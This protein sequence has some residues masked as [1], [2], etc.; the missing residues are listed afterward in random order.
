MGTTSS[1]LNFLSK[2][3]A[4]GV[5]ISR[6]D[7]SQHPLGAISGWPSSLRTALSTTLSAG[8]P[9]FVAWGADFHTFYNAA[10]K[11]IL[12]PK[13]A[14]GHGL[15]LAELWSEVADVVHAMAQDAF[16]G[17]TQYF[18]DRPFVLDRHGY[19]E[20]A[21]FTFCFS[22]IRDEH[23]TVGGILGTLIETTEKVAALAKFRD[24][25]ERYRL[26]LEASG[27]IGT[28][29][30]DPETNTAT[31]DAYF[32][33]L[34]DVDFEIAKNGAAVEVFTERIHPEDRGSVEAAIAE[35]I[36]TGERYDID[37]RIVQRSGKVVW[38]TAKGKL[39]TDVTT[40]KQ[41]FAG[42]SVEITE[43]KALEN[44]LHESN[45]RKDEFLAMLA[46][47][48]RNPL[49]PISAAAQ[50]LLTARLD[51]ERIRKT[52]QIIVRQ[53]DH[54]TGLVN[55]LLDVSRVTRGLATIEKAPVEIRTI[56]ADA[57]EQAA[58]LIHTRRH[59]LAMELAP[60]SAIVDV[61]RK[62]LV[63][64]VANVLNNAAKYT[65][66]DGR[67]CLRTEVQGTHVLI[68]VIDNGIGMTPDLTSQVFDLFTQAHATPD[69][70]SGGLGLGLALVKSLVELHGGSV[71]A[72]SNGLGHGSRFA[73][74]LP[75]AVESATS[76]IST[77]VTAPL[78]TAARAL[79]ILVVDDN[80]DAAETIALLLEAT[81]H[82][83]HIE[84]GAK[85]ALQRTI[86]EMPEVCLLDIGLPEMNGNELARQIRKIPGMDTAVLIA[87]TGYGQEDD[88]ATT[89]AAGFDYHFVKPV[90]TTELASLLARVA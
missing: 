1:D 81:G 43:R 17:A 47:E 72:I 84:Y 24:S 27:N 19:L 76:D 50:L 38:V 28:W 82:E 29:V 16:S 37:Y 9:S 53:V 49:A 25:D 59:H 3:G 80:V 48:L 58:P 40:G 22:P 52:S 78:Q 46:H 51:E 62:R 79:K 10:Y 83:V 57:V 85:R 36:Q 89:R 68:E 65:P 20:R 61:D 90:D 56:V 44:G 31:M 7:W 15:P 64:V 21:Y 70:N 87:L 8:F 18:E 41:Q 60:G 54:M 75:R 23:G 4:I 30:V 42:I 69:R 35:A 63:Q 88:R 66:E 2:S 45:R 32:A 5:E 12:G 6:H 73:I 34:F 11:P 14:L 13:V 26:A 67:I 71:A 77:H 86:T 55:D 74:R 39:F 33:A